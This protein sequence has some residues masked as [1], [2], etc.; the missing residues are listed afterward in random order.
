M[1]IHVHVSQQSHIQTSNYGLKKSWSKDD[2]TMSSNVYFMSSD[3]F[4]YFLFFC[5]Q[6]FL[7][8]ILR[9][10]DIWRASVGTWAVHESFP[11][12]CCCFLPS[13]GCSPTTDLCIY[14]MYCICKW[15]QALWRML[16]PLE[17]RGQN[18]PVS[19]HLG[20]FCVRRCFGTSCTYQTLLQTA[21]TTQKS[22]ELFCFTGRAGF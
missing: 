9:D 12:G 18:S 1:Q 14:C 17:N 11:W 22:S 15:L 21:L 6:K 8:I 16:K 20:L 7:S 19:L 10:L 3:I 5:L 2:I 13:N 4:K